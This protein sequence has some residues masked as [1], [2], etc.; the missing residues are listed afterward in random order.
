MCVRLNLTH[1]L[2]PTS[3]GLL[4]AQDLIIQIHLLGKMWRRPLR[5][6]MDHLA[7]RY[8]TQ[9]L[10]RSPTFV[11]SVQSVHKHF[12]GEFAAGLPAPPTI[13]G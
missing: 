8:I 6:A 4:V 9:P 13:A 7:E 10:L 11:K 12:I 1:Q 3:C 5:A 2:H